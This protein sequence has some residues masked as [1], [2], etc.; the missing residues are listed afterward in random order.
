[1]SREL[2]RRAQQGHLKK[3]MDLAD[4][5]KNMATA[6][7]QLEKA[8]DALVPIHNDK[9]D[10]VD[11]LVNELE[12]ID[13]FLETHDIYNKLGRAYLL[14]CISSHG[15]QRHATRG[16]ALPVNLYLTGRMKKYMDQARDAHNS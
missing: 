1:M 6:L 12:N 15:R 9:D 5:T 3:V 7:D 4:N 11:A 16:G 8:K 10:A 2:V 13:E 14:A